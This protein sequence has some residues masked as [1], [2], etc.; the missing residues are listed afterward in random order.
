[1]A[2]H[3]QD[4]RASPGTPDA[5]L[6]RAYIATSF[7]ADVSGKRLRIRVGNTHTELDAVL[8]THNVGNWVYITACNPASHRLS[9]SENS[10]RQKDLEDWI[11]EAGRVYF[12]GQGVGDDARWPPE[13]SFLVLGISRPEA[14]QWGRK[15]GQNAVAWGAC[16]KAAMLMDCRP[17]N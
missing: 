15:F 8:A 13:P 12:T 6:D 4:D 10:R 5:N 9:D 2:D 1:M 16:G 17:G 7:E 11:R 3:Q 14:I